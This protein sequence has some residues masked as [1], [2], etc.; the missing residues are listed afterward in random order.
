MVY[1]EISALL[2]I[3]GGRSPP[4]LA[5]WR[6]KVAIPRILSVTWDNLSRRIHVVEGGNERVDVP[7]PT[8]I[9]IADIRK[10]L[11]ALGVANGPKLPGFP[12]DRCGW[13]TQVAGQQVRQPQK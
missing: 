2:A 11:T 12:R 5:D 4:Y 6:L 1:R 10:E 13:C 8:T 3:M 7:E 9:P